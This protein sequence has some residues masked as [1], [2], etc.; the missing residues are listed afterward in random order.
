M[1]W[2]RLDS[3]WTVRVPV[4][5]RVGGWEVTAPI[6]TG[7]FGSVYAARRV[8]K[9]PA[10]ASC[11]VALKFMATG[12]MGVR[13]FREIHKL[14]QREVDFSCDANHERLVKVSES[15]VVQ[16]ADVEFDGAVVLVMERAAQSLQDLLDHARG[17]EPVPQ[18]TQLIVQICEALA[19]L[20]T[21][22][23]IHG[24]LKPSNILIMTD[25]SVRLA[26]FGLVTRLEGTHGYG[27]PFGSIDYLPPER[28]DDQLGLRGVRVRPS[29]D[30]W[31][32]GITAH[33]VLT[34]GT[35]SARRAAQ[36]FATGRA[37]LRLPGDLDEGWREFIASCLAPDYA[38]R[39]SVPDLFE[40]ARVLSDRR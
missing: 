36:D 1:N 14:V 2:D 33:Q 21:S 31:A 23:W 29:D 24:D 7:S 40:R 39:S 37:P 26:D 22:G 8:D 25:G 18:A 16:D 32:L 35:S 9:D 34:G 11:I 20:H 38:S 17:R 4:G 10:D 12:P 3:G 30:V 6:A 5:Y 15:L 27:P 28:W 19:Y 13:Q